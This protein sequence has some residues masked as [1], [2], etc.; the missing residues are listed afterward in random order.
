MSHKNIAYGTYKTNTPTKIHTHHTN[1]QLL[2]IA[3]WWLINKILPSFG[4]WQSLTQSNIK[5]PSLIQLVL[6]KHTF[7][8]IP[9]CPPYLSCYIGM[10]RSDKFYRR[11]GCILRQPLVEMDTE[12]HKW[13]G[14]G[15]C[16]IY[17]LWE[18]GK[19]KWLKTTYNFYWKLAITQKFKIADLDSFK[20]LKCQNIVHKL[21]EVY[22]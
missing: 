12:Q 20:S 10:K 15:I 7:Q 2:L 17:S 1:K 13:D 9:F 22:S 19:I 14:V 4:A 8:Q 21:I 16:D 6:S 5:H 18:K 11:F 3:N